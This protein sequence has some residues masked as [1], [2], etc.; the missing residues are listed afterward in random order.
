MTNGVYLS[1]DTLAKRLDTF[2]K[3]HQAIA[4]HILSKPGDL[5]S[6]NIEEFAQAV[7]VSRSSIFRF[8]QVLGLQGYSDLQQQLSALRPILDQEQDDP[9]ISWVT[10]SMY[11]AIYYTLHNLDMVAMQRAVDLMKDAKRIYWYGAG[12][13]GL[14]GELGNHRCWSV[15]I[16]SYA[17][18]ETLDI[19]NFDILKDKSNVFIFISL[20]GS[21]SIIEKSLELVKREGLTCIAITSVRE[22]PLTKVATVN[23]YAASPRATKD[24]NIVPIRAGSE[25]IINSLVYKTA[26]ARN[27]PLKLGS[28]LF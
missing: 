22:S 24:P 28:E 17:F 16:D 1:L 5:L 10:R 4:Q 21:R 3:T 12:E 20:S 18:R 23:L 9:V 2:S 7:G 25:A 15:G 6:L 26:L 11:D 8:C 19:V 27:I 13:S 14:L